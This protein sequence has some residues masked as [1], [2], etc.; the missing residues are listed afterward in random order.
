MKSSGQ[1]A[2]H[3]L[4]APTRINLN[5]GSADRESV[6][7]ELVTQIPELA[8]QP[9]ARQT[10]LRAL[11][12]REQLYSTGIGDGIA[13]PHSRNAL[14]GL[15]DSALVVFGRHPTGIMYGAPDSVPA[16]LFFLVVAPTVTQHLAVLAR[17]IRLLR[18]PKLRQALLTAD[19][20]EKVITILREAEMKL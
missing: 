7:N 11:H 9:E 1:L 20:P 19:K 5:L 18:D 17:L 15:V 8:N 2:L 6:L 12:E 4:L 13:L 14:V 16:R 10:L 3:E